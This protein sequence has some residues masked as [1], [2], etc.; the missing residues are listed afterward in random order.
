MGDMHRLILFRHAKAEAATGED[1]HARALVDAGKAAAR[2][3]GRWLIDNGA[4]P[5]LVICSNSARTR[6]TWDQVS[7]IFAG[8]VGVVFEER[9]YDA[10]ADAVLSLIAETQD[11]VRELLVVGHNPSLEA[12]AAR[13]ARDRTHRAIPTAGILIFDL[14]G[15][16]GALGAGSGD[17][18]AVFKPGSVGT[19]S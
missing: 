4:D 16:W 1:D 12:I 3:A 9:L 17:L 18:R 6:G 19:P 13:L 14:D 10:E 8:D 2:Q 5:D 15:G 7:E 11:D